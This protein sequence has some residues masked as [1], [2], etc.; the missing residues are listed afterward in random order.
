MDSHGNGATSI[1]SAWSGGYGYIDVAYA[2]MAIKYG[3]VIT[4]LIGSLWVIMT[5]RALRAGNSEIAFALAVLAVHGFSEARIMDINYNIFLVMQ[6]C[7]FGHPLVK[8]EKQGKIPWLQICTGVAIIGAI[9]IILPK[10]LS[11]LR[12]YFYLKGWNDGIAAFYSF[13]FCVALVLLLTLSWRSICTYWT[14]RKRI[15]LL[16]TIIVL[17]FLAVGY[18]S[19]D[20][21]ITLGKEE[22]KERLQTERRVIALIQSVATEPVFAAE[23]EELYCRSGVG[24]SKHIFSSEELG[25]TRGTLIVD[26]NIESFATVRYG[27]QYAKLSEWS[28]IYSYDVAVKEALSDL[29]WK[30]F[31]SGKRN[32]N[33]SDMAV[34]NGIGRKDALI[35]CDGKRVETKNAVSDQFAGEYKVCFN[36]SELKSESNSDVVL[37][38]IIGE[39]GERKIWQ[40]MLVPADFDENGQC[41]YTISYKIGDT[42]KVTYALTAMD[43]VSVKI[44]NITWWREL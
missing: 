9:Y 3:W 22:Q 26:K 12:T 19:T 20:N 2:M 16:Q 27:G 36:L 7:T 23:A 44:D 25:R 41:E 18:F 35:I 40:Q 24:L 5:V 17:S 4:L 11:W 30:D 37:L 38:E 43:G 42:P 13:V 34:F 33:L 31:Y 32:V 8:E 6:F 1:H 15:H 28:G 14:K 10:A 21:T 29:E 39:A